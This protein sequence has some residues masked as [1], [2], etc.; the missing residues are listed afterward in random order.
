MTSCGL[1]WLLLLTLFL[2]PI[3]CT[4]IFLSN[5]ITSSQTTGLVYYGPTS[6]I[7]ALQHWAHSLLCQGPIL[8]GSDMLDLTSGL[9]VSTKLG[10]WIVFVWIYSKERKI[11]RLWS[12]FEFLIFKYLFNRFYLLSS[13]KSIIKLTY[14]LKNPTIVFVNVKFKLSFK[15][16]NWIEL[17]FF[18]KK[19][20]ELFRKHNN[21]KLKILY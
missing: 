5:P 21:L 13:I 19:I 8:V 10:N 16:P 9:P 11:S 18:K 20:D 12:T 14:Y 6:V 4:L 3:K 7:K 2:S 17:F 15:K 1:V